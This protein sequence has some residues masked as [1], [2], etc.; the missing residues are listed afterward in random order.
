MESKE[1]SNSSNII[2]VI[3]II[4]IIVIGGCFIYAYNENYNSEDME[5]QKSRE[6]TEA[7][8]QRYEDSVRDYNNLRSDIEIY[9]RSANRVKNAK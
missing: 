3:I 1:K 7:A 9:K 5:L 4:A 6:N 8:R 2:I